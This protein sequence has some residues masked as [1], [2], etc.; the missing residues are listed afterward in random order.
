MIYK[1]KIGIEIDDVQSK[2]KRQ[3]CI[4]DMEEPIQTK[5]KKIVFP[6]EYF[7]PH[8]YIIGVSL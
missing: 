3:Q 7:V 8:E 5:G 2:K 1:V 6:W 4:F